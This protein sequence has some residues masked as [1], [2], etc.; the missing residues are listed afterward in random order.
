MPRCAMTASRGASVRGPAALT[1]LIRCEYTTIESSLL[2]RQSFP[3]LLQDPSIRIESS[4]RSSGGKRRAV[5]YGIP[6]RCPLFLRDGVIAIV[7]AGAIFRV[8]PSTGAG[9]AISFFSSVPRVS[10]VE[11]SIDLVTCCPPG[12]HPDGAVDTFLS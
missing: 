2:I 5:C 10:C 6:S 4:N 1:R 12:S 7:V 11:G 9:G 8:T 3:I